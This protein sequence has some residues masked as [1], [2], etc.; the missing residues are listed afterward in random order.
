VKRIEQ[1]P[2]CAL[3]YVEDGQGRRVIA[4]MESR[5][6]GIYEHPATLAMNKKDIDRVIRILGA[7]RDELPE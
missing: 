2:Q 4:A 7:L 1:G 5:H 3:A 6:S